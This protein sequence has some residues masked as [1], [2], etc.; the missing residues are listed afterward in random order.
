M[1]SSYARIYLYFHQVPI[2]FCP[3]NW[4]GT[5]NR[6]W[7]VDDKLTQVLTD[8]TPSVVAPGDRKKIIK[9]WT[10]D[11]NLYI[12]KKNFMTNGNESLQ[13][14]ITAIEES[15]NSWKTQCIILLYRHKKQLY[16]IIRVFWAIESKSDV[17]HF[18]W[19]T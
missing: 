13:F 5:A 17:M 14:N 3:A 7:E 15:N 16:L 8:C 2:N 6:G 1:Q 4:R 18:R 11:K 10:E 9:P 12:I 19:Q